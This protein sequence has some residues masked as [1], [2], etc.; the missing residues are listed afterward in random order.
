[1]GGK[2]KKERHL[3][4]NIFLCFIFPFTAPCKHNFLTK[5]LGSLFTLSSRFVLVQ[6]LYWDSVQNSDLKLN[7]KTNLI[8]SA[9]RKYHVIL[10]L[11]KDST[12]LPSKGHSYVYV[13]IQFCCPVGNFWSHP[14]IEK[15]HADSFDSYEER[16]YMSVTLLL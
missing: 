13:S 4:Y 10:L 3:F 1:M 5:D 8:K 6:V 11:Q 16:G 15:K 14:A 12:D 7:Q 9:D 2:K